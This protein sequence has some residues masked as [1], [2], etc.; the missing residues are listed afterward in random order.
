MNVGALLNRT[1][2]L[3]RRTALVV[4][5]TAAIASHSP[6]IQPPRDS[7]MKVTLAGAGTVTVIGTVN[8]SS[9]SE[10]ITFTVPSVKR[11]L[12]EF[13]SITSVDTSGASGV[14]IT[15]EA[16]DS[17]GNSQ[18]TESTYQTGWPASNTFDTFGGAYPVN[19]QGTQADR[20]GKLALGYSLTFVPRAGDIVIDEQD[21][22]RWLIIRVDTL[23]S[24]IRPSHW[25]CLV[26][27]FNP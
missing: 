14:D 27:L 12:R 21:T 8:G 19:N 3:V 13:D 6:A 11:T 17:G 4:E 10:V 1:V 15:V 5:T 22:N 26:Q 23:P 25:E 18:K 24:V 7:S 9:D 2:T 16:V 20:T